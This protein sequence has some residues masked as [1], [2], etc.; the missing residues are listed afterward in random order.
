MREP[1]KTANCRE[2]GAD[3][4]SQI[5]DGAVH[6]EAHSVQD[7]SE[8]NH[9]QEQR[10]WMEKYWEMLDRQMQNDAYFKVR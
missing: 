1:G 2:P 4:A 10:E 3:V 6:D 8:E 7:R 9:L 5:D